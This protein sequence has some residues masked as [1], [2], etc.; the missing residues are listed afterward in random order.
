M[1]RWRWLDVF[2]AAVAGGSLVAAALVVPSAA[3]VW[4]PSWGALADLCWV[5][6][7]SGLECPYCGMTR[8]FASFL[9]GDLSTA[10]RMHPAGP[11]L[12]V[13]LGAIVVWVLFCA[14]TGRPAVSNRPG[15]LQAFAGVALVSLALGLVRWIL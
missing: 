12:A 7:W 8:S 11:L 9:H 6:T 13:A 2:V 10:F 3:S 14:G 15:F 5:R 1:N 4:L